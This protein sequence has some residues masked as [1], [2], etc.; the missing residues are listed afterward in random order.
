M[1]T[2]TRTDMRVVRHERIRKGLKG[3]SDRPRL[4][5]FR[6]LKHISAQI[7][8]DTKGHTLAAAS[9]QEA[10][11]KASDN[12]SG[13]EKVGAALAER[14]KQAGVSTVVFDRGGFKYHGTVAALADAVRKGG[15]EF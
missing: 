3:T 5:V 8:D 4:A 9:S 14:A 6:S 2:K 12:V 10:S 15:V 1:A 11:L 7:I 13:A